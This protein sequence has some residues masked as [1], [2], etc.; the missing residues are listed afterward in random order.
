MSRLK[1]IWL[2]IQ[3]SLWFVPSLIT[4]GSI[5]LAFGLIE[6]DRRVVDTE[7]IGE[8]FFIFGAGSTGARGMLT[9]IAQ[10][11]MTVTGVVFS[12]TI[13]ALQ[14]AST[15]FTPR[16]LVRFTDDRGNQIVLGI[17]IATFTF[18][19]LVLRVVRA[20]DEFVP[21]ISITVAILLALVSVGALIYFVDHIANSL[22][23]ET[24]I[25]RVVKETEQVIA[26]VYPR[27]PDGGGT[28]LPF[29]PEER[30]EPDG[31]P[32]LLRA[33]SSGFLQGIDERTVAEAADG[34]LT[35]EMRIEIGEFI[36]EGE[37]LA[38]VW[39]ATALDDRDT[40][41]RLTAS[42][43]LGAERTPQQDVQ[44]GLVELVDI[45]V[46][47]LSPSIFEPT[48]T[49]V[50]IHRIGELLVQI[51]RG[52]PPTTFRSSGDGRI[53]FIA[54]HASFESAVRL[55][56]RPIRR[57]G[58]EQAAI[59]M[60]LLDMLG[61]VGK[62]VPEACRA[63]LVVEVE[64]TLRRAE[65]AV[66]SRMDLDEIREEGRRALERIRGAPAVAPERA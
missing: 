63:C 25:S 21:A 38:R 8:Y 54:E 30:F 19:L 35:L 3:D 39:P 34:R 51:G 32:A 9:A 41:A 12:V 16:V 18:S 14:L 66:D 44:R 43:M 60:K 65:S 31:E 64:E 59:L 2:Q 55:S 17:F 53:R 37:P 56:V 62:L 4:I 10:S 36:I 61:R 1:A 20:D 22:K 47:A 57:Y 29:E 40:A 50:C 13:I 15:Q 26:R 5:I 52:A 24:I 45:A 7:Y 23:A 11:I 49:I 46:K 33:R 6:L 27:E 28:T 48:T 42:F 58:E